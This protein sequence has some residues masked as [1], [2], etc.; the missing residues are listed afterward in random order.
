MKAC[1]EA[2]VVLLDSSDN[3]YTGLQAPGPFLNFGR[4]LH[5][6]GVCFTML[7]STKRS[8]D[9]GRWESSSYV[10]LVCRLA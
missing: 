7:I 8:L 3:G 6:R 5:T 2:V 4:G 10:W 9:G 1:L